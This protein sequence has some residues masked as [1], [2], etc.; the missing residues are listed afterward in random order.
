M[1]DIQLIGLK[2]DDLKNDGLLRMLS[3]EVRHLP[4]FTFRGSVG[5]K[6]RSFVS[7]L[8]VSK[9]DKLIS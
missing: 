4:A 6:S 1:R 5:I 8:K 2:G 7:R 3:G 9:I